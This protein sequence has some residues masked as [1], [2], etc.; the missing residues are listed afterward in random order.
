MTKPTIVLVP[1]AWHVPEHFQKVQKLL[2]AEGYSCVGVNLP[3]NAHEP[4][5]DGKLVD[6]ND[7]VSAA[8]LVV[9]RVLESGEDVV[10][11]VHSYGTL[12]GT[13]ALRDL[14]PNARKAA[15]HANGVRSL[16]IIAG[17]VLPEGISMLQAMG[18]QLLP[19]YLHDG[20]TTLPFAGPGAIEVLYNDLD[21]L[22]AQ[23]AVWRLKPQSYAIN[24]TPMPDAAAAIRGI[25]VSYL[26]C[27]KDNACPYPMQIQT[28]DALKAMGQSV[29]TEVAPTGHSPF[30]K[31]PEETARFV[32]KAAGED[33]ESGFK[34]L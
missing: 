12:V 30:I 23:K 4:Y 28:I 34:G 2:E 32:R 19:Q 9:T 16:V 27:D 21:T 31:M 29:H 20:D 11:V 1:G 33:L 17:F 6:F 26:A 13:A 24:T 3:S 18:G 10:V 5:I 25:H 14:S 15:G 8:R 22:E 7:D